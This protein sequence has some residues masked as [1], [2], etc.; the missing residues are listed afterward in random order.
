MLSI[1]GVALV[2]MSFGFD[3][4]FRGFAIGG[5]IIC[6]G[7]A[8]FILGSKAHTAQLDEDQNSEWLPS[9][10]STESRTE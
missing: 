2:A 7:L 10:D 4:F 6:F 1:L 3:D 8:G 9:R 5:A